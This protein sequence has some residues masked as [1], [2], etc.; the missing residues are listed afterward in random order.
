VHPLLRPRTGALP[1][2]RLHAHAS[3]GDPVRPV[4]HSNQVPVMTE[5]TAGLP[6]SDQRP[7]GDVSIHLE[8]LVDD[9]QVVAPSDRVSS[10]ANPIRV[11]LVGQ[12]MRVTGTFDIGRFQRLSDF[13]NHH[14]GMLA[15][16]DVTILRRNGEPTRV[17]A[18][19]LWISP[20]EVTIFGQLD[21]HAPSS[22]DGLQ[23]PKITHA[24]IYV[25]PGHTLTG[26]LYGPDGGDLAALVEST[27]PVF[28]PLTDV[29]TRSLADRR[30]I[31]RYP[32]ALL[33][34]HHVVAATE[35]AEGMQPGRRVL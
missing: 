20:E 4:F 14:V 23:I 17:T 24:M 13:M 21:T 26:E 33:N 28:V 29:R 8:D 15:L 11:E 25:T 34:R 2:A 7:D 32:F 35:M 10:L 5:P 9:G 19:R 22:A 12:H 27:D 16:Y 18:Q 3:G 30:I 6:A 1:T 31:S